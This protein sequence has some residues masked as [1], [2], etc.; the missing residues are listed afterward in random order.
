M[1]SVRVNVAAIEP[2]PTDPSEQSE[3]FDREVGREKRVWRA[4]GWDLRPSGTSKRIDGFEVRA[5]IE[6]VEGGYVIVTVL[7]SDGLCS[8]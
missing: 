2:P 4:H 8:G 5:S 7:N 3:W 1:A 6:P